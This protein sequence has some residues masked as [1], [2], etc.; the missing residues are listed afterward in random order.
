MLASDIY[1]HSSI[2][3]VV[4]G[5]CNDGLFRLAFDKKVTVLIDSVDSLYE[6]HVG[7]LALQSKVNLA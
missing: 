5:Q 2:F 1:V 3:I 6:Q 7:E 4:T